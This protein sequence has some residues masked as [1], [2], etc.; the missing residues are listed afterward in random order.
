MRK[1]IR[2]G[3]KRLNDITSQ[4]IR[5]AG[6]RTCSTECEKHDCSRQRTLVVKQRCTVGRKTECGRRCRKRDTGR[7]A[8]AGGAAER[9]RVN[10]K[11]DNTRHSHIVRTDA[12]GKGRGS[13]GRVFRVGRGRIFSLGRG[14]CGARRTQPAHRTRHSRGCRNARGRARDGILPPQRH[15]PHRSIRRALS[16][17]HAAHARPSA[18]AVRMRPCRGFAASGHSLRRHKEHVGIR[19]GHVRHP[20]RR[21]GEVSSR[22]GHCQRLGLRHRC[23]RTPRRPRG[24]LDDRRIHSQ[25]PAA[26]DTARTR[27]ARRRDHRRRRSHSIGAKFAVAPERASLHTAQPSHCRHVGRNCRRGVARSWRVSHNGRLRRRLF[28]HGDGGARARHGHAF[29]RHQRPDTQ[30][31]GRARSLGRRYG[32]GTYVGSG[33]AARRAAARGAPADR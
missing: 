24:G 32:G 9:I 29:A 30:P 1:A 4:G 18:R 2:N 20:H 8:G 22:R 7:P 33:H 14:A 11:Y 15:H 31:Q 23:R 28:T 6:R 12:R 5:N 16:A 3:C 19:A 26:G 17:A 10:I 27:E 21:V 25:R 13:S